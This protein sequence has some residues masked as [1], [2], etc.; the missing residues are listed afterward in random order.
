MM[1]TRD[2]ILTTLVRSQENLF[3]RYQAFTPDEL[4]RVCTSSEVPDGTPWNPKDHLAHLAL[5]EH[6]FQRM[7]RETL[8]DE[9]DP[10]GFTKIGAQNRQE[11]LAW[12]HRQNQAYAETHHNDSLAQVLADLQ[13]T[14][15]ESLALLELLSDEQLALPV[16]GAPWADGTIGGLL[17]TNA[18]HATQ[19]L[20]WVDAGLQPPE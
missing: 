15:A 2:E 18:A 6:A 4:E 17:I 14:R 8:Q 3:A 12:I 7:I 19:H 5:I 9:V 16:R 10:V 1:P 13:A 11:I 20:G